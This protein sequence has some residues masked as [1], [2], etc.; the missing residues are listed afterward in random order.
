MGEFAAVNGCRLYCEISGDGQPVVLLHGFTFDTRMWD[1]QVAAL[2][3]NFRVLRYDM[4]G[5]GRSDPP[6]AEGYSQV[7]DLAALMDARGLGS[8][9]VIGQSRGGAVAIDFALTHPERV[10]K[11]VLIDTVL[12]GFRWSPE[13]AARDGKIWAV[14]EKG[15]V[16]AA[17]ESWLSHPL[18]DSAQAHPEAATRIRQ[19]AESY[20]GWHFVNANPEIYL[21]PPAVG[22]LGELSAPTLVIVGELDLPDFQRI[23]E[24]VATQAPHAR[25][26]RIPGAGHMSNM[27]APDRVND[28]ILEF[29]NQS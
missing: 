5:F 28:V 19:I 15:G 23:S 4:R 17:R 25:L 9:H 24:Q 26:V 18:F 16:Q 6:A 7:D 2:Q 14:A 29:L 27:E 20:S 12:G 11:L 3:P 21:D 8:A 13:L 1:D 22:R 10:D